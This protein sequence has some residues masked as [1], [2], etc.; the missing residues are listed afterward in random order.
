MSM[1]SLRNHPVWLNMSP[2]K[3]EIMEEAIY[4]GAGK[5]INESAGVIMTAMKRMRKSGESFSKEES[6]ILIDELMKGM[7]ARERTRAE[8]IRNMIR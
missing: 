5:S 6:D 1:E 4:A 8:M 7:S 2:V 3:R